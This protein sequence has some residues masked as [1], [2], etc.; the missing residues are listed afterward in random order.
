MSIRLDFDDH[1]VTNVGSATSDA[2]GVAEPELQ[3]S[4]AHR[5]GT[6]SGDCSGLGHGGKPLAGLTGTA[7]RSIMP[8]MQETGTG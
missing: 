6:H 1:V 7:A 2:E 4:M 5:Q 8:A 3:R